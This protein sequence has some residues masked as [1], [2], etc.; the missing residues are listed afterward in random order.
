MRAPDLK[1]APL[2]GPLSP[3]VRPA[4]RVRAYLKAEF[5]LNDCA[6]GTRL[7]SV[8]QVARRVGVSTATVQSVFQKMS[9]AGLIRSAVG[10][11]SFWVGNSASRGEVLQIG[12]NIPVPHGAL[13][14][15]WTYQIYG[16]ILHGVLQSGRQILL[17]SLPWEALDSEVYGARFLEESQRLDGLILFPF[18]FSKRLRKLSERERKPVVDLN[19][20]SETATANFVSPDYYSASRIIGEALRRSGRRKL[21]LLVSPGMEESVSVRLRC[22]GFV[23]GIGE[24]LG[25]GV[26]L[27]VIKV[28]DRDE[29]T[30]SV[31]VRQMLEEGYRP[32]GIYCAGDSLAL[33]CLRELERAGIAVPE[34]VSVI[35][36]NGLGLHSGTSPALTSMR[37][38]LDLLGAELVTV[39]LQQIE[40]EGSAVPG[41][42]FPPIFNIGATTRC[43][44]NA[45]LEEMAAEG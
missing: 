33:G 40:G 45:V 12:I 18:R 20:S 2:S 22:A 19:P 29:G 23:A 36:G 15:G 4:E 21:A 41:R 35:G 3:D 11:G 24:A 42:Y 9:E 37:H 31:A 10:S 26:D 16:G 28:G 5:E 38:A 14:S 17:R 7:P 39:L 8:R 1:T 25:A 30:G 44:E 6:E 43:V 13:P 34:E 27:R 32:D